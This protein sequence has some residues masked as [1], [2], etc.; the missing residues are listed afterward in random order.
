MYRNTVNP[1]AEIYSNGKKLYTIDLTAVS[2]PYLITV[3]D[4]NSGTNIIE[5][6]NGEIGVI[7]AD[8]P[9]KTCVH[10]GFA[11]SSTLRIIC[12]PHKLEIRII[13]GKTN[14]DGVSG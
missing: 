6:R 5:V 13:D 4:E 7:S 10:T 14:I 3:A 11:G 8:C 9:D 2:E 1:V 12:I